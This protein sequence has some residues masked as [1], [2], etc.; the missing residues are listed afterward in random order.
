V[1]LMTGGDPIG[2]RIAVKSTEDGINRAT[3]G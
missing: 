1:A 3:L 2:A